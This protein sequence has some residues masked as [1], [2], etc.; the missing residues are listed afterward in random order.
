[1]ELKNY[2]CVE[3]QALYGVIRTAVNEIFEDNFGGSYDT[4]TKDLAFEKA[5]IHR[6]GLNIKMFILMY[7]DLVV[8]LYQQ[9]IVRSVQSEEFNLENFEKKIGKQVK[10]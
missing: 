10:K 3:D 2:G 7:V 8:D 1:M 6:V 5:D 9:S 4:T